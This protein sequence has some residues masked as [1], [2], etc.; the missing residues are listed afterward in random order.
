MECI[1]KTFANIFRDLRQKTGKSRYNMAKF[2]GL[3]ESYLLRLETGERNNPSRDVVLMIGLALVR[4]SNLVEIWDIDNLLMSA[5]HSPL[6]KRGP[7]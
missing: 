5:E 7:K 4:Q 1:M 3:D 2:T 6:R